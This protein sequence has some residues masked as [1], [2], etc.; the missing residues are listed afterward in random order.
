[1]LNK[2]VARPPPP[3]AQSYCTHTHTHEGK[4]TRLN[5]HTQRLTY[6]HTIRPQQ[7]SKYA[8]K[9]HVRTQIGTR[10]HINTAAHAC[11]DHTKHG[12]GQRPRE[13]PQDRTQDGQPRT[14]SRRDNNISVT[15]LPLTS[16][17]VTAHRERIEEPGKGSDCAPRLSQPNLI[18]PNLAWSSAASPDLTF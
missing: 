2:G 11:A 9:K 17:P 1:M 5:G 16:W 7:Q 13:T 6:G 8:L 18:Q 14:S 3:P 4:C 10:A 15:S 12:G